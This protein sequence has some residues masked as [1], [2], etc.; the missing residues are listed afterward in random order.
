MTG[1]LTANAAKKRSS[2]FSVL[3][4]LQR[5][6]CVTT[7]YSPEVLLL[8]CT[9]WMFTFGSESFDSPRRQGF[10]TT[11]MIIKVDVL[12]TQIQPQKQMHLFICGFCL[13][14]NLCSLGHYLCYE[15]VLFFLSM[16]RGYTS[17]F[18][19]ASRICKVRD[20]GKRWMSTEV[21][22]VYRYHNTWVNT[23]IVMSDSQPNTL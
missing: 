8:D 22:Y 4:N 11:Q 20:G 12:K 17:I 2:S 1:T 9:Y 7:V 3:I 23:Y 21:C 13:K 19:Q 14:G 18:V 15:V 16:S 5:Q 10:H 6:E